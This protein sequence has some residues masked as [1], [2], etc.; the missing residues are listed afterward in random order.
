VLPVKR[1]PGKVM[2]PAKRGQS[3][4]SKTDIGQ[5]CFSQSENNPPDKFLLA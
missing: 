2:M 4:I 5:P 1:K 3:D